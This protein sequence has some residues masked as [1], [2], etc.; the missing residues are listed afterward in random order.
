MG[1]ADGKLY[2]Q[3]GSTEDGSLPLKKE[4]KKKA[5]KESNVEPKP[6]SKPKAGEDEG[7][8]N[9][10]SDPRVKRTK[11]NGRET[12]PASS[13]EQKN[14]TSPSPVLDSP[15]R[16]GAGTSTESD[17]GHGSRS[18]SNGAQENSTTAV[19]ATEVDDSIFEYLFIEDVP[20]GM[21]PVLKWKYEKEK[22]PTT[23]EQ[24]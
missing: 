9:H 18:T 8:S 19:E 7:E 13:K 4:R 3:K 10:I 20:K 1:S 5:K 21:I 23:T 24:I 11:I 17:S 22:D 15:I 12:V 2:K 14:S 6:K 16:E